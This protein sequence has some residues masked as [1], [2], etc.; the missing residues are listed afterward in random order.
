M[1]RVLADLLNDRGDVAD[2]VDIMES[3]GRDVRK[4]LAGVAKSG[5]LLRSCLRDVG[6]RLYL[7]GRAR[8]AAALAEECVAIS[9]AAAD[10]RET[11]IDLIRS[12]RYSDIRERALARATEAIELLEAG[13]ADE[14]YELLIEAHATKSWLHVRFGEFDAAVAAADNLIALAT[15]TDGSPA[16]AR[17]WL[18]D[19]LHVRCAC[20]HALGDLPGALADADRLIGLISAD[21]TGVRQ[22]LPDWLSEKAWILA[23]LG[24]HYEAVAV[25]RELE[26]RTEAS[27]SG[28]DARAGLFHKVLKVAPEEMLA[29]W[30]DAT[31]QDWPVEIAR[32]AG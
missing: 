11:A 16:S 28:D 32:E 14:N 23:K 21:E 29:A 27:D 6:A 18:A 15:S 9:R 20:R 1:S 25:L 13:P 8:S 17:R 19:G 7:Y 10:R 24:R 30:Q 31:G 22:Q 26:L 12:A 4:A 2:A 3:A 5:L